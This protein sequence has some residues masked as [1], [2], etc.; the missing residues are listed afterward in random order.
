MRKTILIVG[1]SVALVSAVNAQDETFASKMREV[2]AA[3][4]IPDQL[5][6]EA[7]ALATLQA[8]AKQKS[9]CVPTGLRMERPTPATADRMAIQSIQAGKL[10]NL[11]LAYGNAIGCP[12]A[13]KIRFI[14]LQ[15]PDGSVRARVVNQGESIASPSLMRD[16]SAG[17]ALAAWN[18]VKG[19]DSTCDGRDLD[20]TN[21]K[22]S[23]KSA[24][25]S[26]DFYSARYRGSWEEVWTFS[27]CGRQAAVPVSFK[28]DGTGGAYTNVSQKAVSLTKP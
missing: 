27:V 9:Q 25:L 21:T 23:L 20:M 5:A 15:L 12:D 8:I 10:K 7:D 18:A 6:V 26:P 16:T 17:A 28:A 2:N 24:D 19:V 11:W 13:S 14:V 3:V 4:P 22:V 1:L